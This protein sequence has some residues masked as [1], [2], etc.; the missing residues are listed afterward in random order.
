MADAIITQVEA[1]TLLA[2]PKVSTQTQPPLFPTGG[3]RIEVPLES[4]DGR[5]S[6]ALDVT[7]VRI[8][9]T[10]ATYQNR[11]RQVVILAR[12]DID[13]APHRNPDGVEIPCPHIHIYRE[14]F[15]DKWAKP[16]PSIFANP[17]DLWSTLEDFCRFCNVL[18][19]V[20][21]MRGLVV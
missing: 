13:G 12:V 8:K 1:D 9:L 15:G 7:R 21:V 20:P 10:K 3:S 6:F 14:G 19:P 5:E 2:M 16:L 4:E 11:T 17:T 18:G